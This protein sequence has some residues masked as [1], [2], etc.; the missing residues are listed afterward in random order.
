MKVMSEYL[1]KH[2]ALERVKELEAD[3]ARVTAERDVAFENV[4][5][6]D[7]QIEKME[8]DAGFLQRDINDLKSGSEVVRANTACGSETSIECRPWAHL[9]KDGDQ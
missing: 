8:I 6:L 1:A 3:L 7:N 2:A 5:I 9:V 4:R